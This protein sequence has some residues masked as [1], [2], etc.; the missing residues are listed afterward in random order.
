MVDWSGLDWP[1][2]FEQHKLKL[3]NRV[4]TPQ[5]IMLQKGSSHGE[6]SVVRA[7]VGE[8]TCSGESGGNFERR[9]ERNGTDVSARG[10]YMK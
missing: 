4:V 3:L 1:W 5:L 8:M 10:T 6:V 2:T 9:G 7:A